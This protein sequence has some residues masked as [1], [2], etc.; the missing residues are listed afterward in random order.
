MERIGGF[1]VEPQTQL[2][3]G[4]QML[5]QLYVFHL[6]CVLVFL[7]L[8]AT[9]ISLCDKKTC[10]PI[11]LSFTYDPCSHLDCLSSISKNPQKGFL[12]AQRGRP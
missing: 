9:E 11:A 8:V 3:P 12:L 6:L 10:L 2:A 5:S 1:E 7:S 4:I